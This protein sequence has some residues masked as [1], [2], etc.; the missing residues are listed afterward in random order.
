MTAALLLILPY[1]LSNKFQ[2]THNFSELASDLDRLS[3]THSTLATRINGVD[4]LR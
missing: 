1:L 4:S 2:V 3:T